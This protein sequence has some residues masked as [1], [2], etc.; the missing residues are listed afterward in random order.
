M[1]AFAVRRLPRKLRR[2]GLISKRA[3]DKKG[4]SKEREEDGQEEPPTSSNRYK[5]DVQRI[6]GD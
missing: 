3:A 6:Y 5:D 1:P 2:A 4:L